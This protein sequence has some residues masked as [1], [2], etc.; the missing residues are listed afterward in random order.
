[1]EDIKKYYNNKKVFITGITGF[2]GSW[3]ALLLHK[4]GAKVSGLGLLEDKEGI[5]EKSEITS[6]APVYIENI[7]SKLSKDVEEEILQSDIIFHLAAQPLVSEGYKNPYE[8]FQTNL[9]GTIQILELLKKPTK[10]VVFFNVTTDKVYQPSKFSHKEDDVLFG[11]DP[12]SLS[13]SFSDMATQ[14]Y[15]ENILPKNVKIYTARAGNVLGGGDRSKDRI[16]TDI[17]NHVFYCNKIL[18]IR[19]PYSIRPYQYVLD[20]VMQYILLPVS[21]KPSSYNIGPEKGEVVTTIDLIDFFAKQY[22]KIEYVITK[23]DIGKENQTLTLNTE[24]TKFV[25]N[26]EPYCRNIDDVTKLTAS[27]EKAF[28]FDTETGKKEIAR[29][30]D[31][32]IKHYTGE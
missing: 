31:L 5:F 7:C 27:Y 12:Y 25:L 22:G 28:R 8:T 14:M 24:K 18:T 30:L 15:K 20:C 9:M 6:F 19:N 26:K 3:L 32:F 2:K 21:D 1:M 11:K 16:S 4:L 17:Y 10:E 23:S 13:K 29:Q